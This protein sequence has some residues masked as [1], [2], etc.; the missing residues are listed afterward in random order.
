[1]P[2]S[3]NFGNALVRLFLTDTIRGSGNTKFGDHIMNNVMRKYW[4][5]GGMIGNLEGR[6]GHEFEHCIDFH[7]FLGDKKIADYKKLSAIFYPKKD[8]NLSTGCARD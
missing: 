7:P 1:M 6:I 5:G 8:G 3:T 2:F 4:G